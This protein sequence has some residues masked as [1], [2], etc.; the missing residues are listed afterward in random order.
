MPI[1]GRRSSGRAGGPVTE[2][3]T[4]ETNKKQENRYQLCLF[5]FINNLDLKNNNKTYRKS[6]IL[7]FWVPEWLQ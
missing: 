5:L 6:L 1:K 2:L 4:V 3:R 7:N